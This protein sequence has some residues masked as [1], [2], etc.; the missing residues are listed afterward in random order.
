MFG[1]FLDKRLITH[2]T[3][4]IYRTDLK[5]KEILTKLEEKKEE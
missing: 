3:N 1:S 4:Q 2:L 5:I